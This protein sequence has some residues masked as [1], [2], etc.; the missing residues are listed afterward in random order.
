MNHSLIRAGAALL[1]ALALSPPAYAATIPFSDVPQGAWFE[2]AAEYCRVNGLL[3]GTALDRFAPYD[4]LSRAQLAV[5][6]HRLF[7]SPA[8]EGYAPFDDVPDDA[9]FA[10]AVAWANQ[11]QVMGGLDN[12]LFAPEQSVSRQQLATTL[13]RCAGSPDAQSSPFADRDQ[14]APFAA[15]AVDWVRAASIMSG[16]DL[17]RFAPNE[18][19]SRAQLATALM[20]YANRTKSATVMSAM[21]VLCQPCGLAAMP[22]GSLLVS[23]RYNKLIWLVSSGKATV[24]AGA[25]TVEDVYGQPIG[26][27]HDA[28][29]L[30]SVFKDPWAISPFLGGWAVSDPKN[31]VVRFLRTN[32]SNHS[33]RTAVTD[34]GVSFDHPTGLA[35]DPDG[36]LYVAET[37]LGTIIKIT[38]DAQVSTF[39]SDL[40]EPMGLC[41]A[42]DALFIAESGG[43]R[44]LKV[45]P[46]GQPSLVAGS[47]SNA[48][49]DGPINHAAFSGPKGVAVAPDGTV[50]VADTDNGAVRRVRD[51]QVSTILSRDPMDTSVTYPTS[52]T[53]LLLQNNTLYISDT[54]ARKLL[55]LPL[56]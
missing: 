21:D 32:D 11:N 17:I 13:W 29:F 40:S 4:T 20:R 54:F 27:Y 44:I 10:Q 31:G 46:N 49:Q 55:A 24:F 5:A 43:N 28:D 8:V 15:T 12:H 48:Y 53:G 34:L 18:P 38:P 39:L 35:T 14:V 36:N 25:Q 47:G 9:W 37:F 7:G 22:D 41:W 3:G 52:P 6:L 2:S 23:D 16:V 19:V 42:N 56:T 51:G 1:C 33:N 50:Y 45:S 26:G 30:D